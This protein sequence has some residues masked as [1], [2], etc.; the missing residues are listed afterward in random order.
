MNFGISKVSEIFDE[1]K[2]DENLFK[3]LEVYLYF[4][5]EGKDMYGTETREGHRQPKEINFYDVK[6]STGKY[7]IDHIIPQSLYSGNP[8]DNIV[9][10]ESTNN[11]I[12]DKDVPDEATVYEMKNFWLYLMKKGAISKK[13]FSFLTKIEQGGLSNEDKFGFINR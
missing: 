10:T 2:K 3:E 11:K 5:Q 7:H 1:V 12:K 4:L 13:K 8:L 9:L 6:N